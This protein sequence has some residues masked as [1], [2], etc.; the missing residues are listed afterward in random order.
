MIR[1]A[2]LGAGGFIGNRIV[3]MLTLLGLAEVRPIVRRTQSLALASRF[4]LDTRIADG[5]D[6]QALGSAFAGCDFVIHAIAGGPATIAGTLEPVYR[7]AA[8]AG[9]RRMAYLSSA[10]VHG[11]S[12]RAGTTDDSPLPKRQP[13]AYNN[14]KAAAERRLVKLRAAGPTEL[15]ILRPGIVHGPRS[16]WTAGF[17]DHL[18]AGTAVLLDAGRGICNSIYVDNLVHAI[19]LALNTPAADGR[20]YL[21]GDAET[22]TWADLYR[23]IARALGRELEDLPPPRIAGRDPLARR[24]WRSPAGTWLRQRVP[25]P[26][27]AGVKAALHSLD[28]PAALGDTPPAPPIADLETTLLQR[29]EVKL[30]HHRATRELGYVPPVAF[31]VA[32]TRTIGWLGFAGYPV[33]EGKGGGRIGW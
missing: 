21:V 13:L 32:M 22:V 11:Q 9:V 16:Q 27:R 33:V 12:P 10:S 18:L 20:S 2:V 30:P 31:D 28:E 4:R 7:A 14:A 8:A 26:V 29:C 19:W 17:A 15:V 6:R 1:V 25:R 5:G 3:E 24:L 23:P